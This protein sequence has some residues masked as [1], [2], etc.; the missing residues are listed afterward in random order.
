MNKKLFLLLLMA[1]CLT[2][3]SAQVWLGGEMSYQ[4]TDLHTNHSGTNTEHEFSIVPEIGF[5]LNEKWGVAT[6]LRFEHGYGGNHDMTNSFIIRPYV[7]YFWA[8]YDKWHI[9]TDG[10]LFFSSTHSCGTDENINSFG[11]F[12]SPGISYS[13]NDRFGLEAHLGDIT[14]RNKNVDDFKENN[15]SLMINTEFSIGFYVNL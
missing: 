11:V 3:A 10:G 9:L 4:M 6:Q 7:R 8:H 12:F 15:F 2:A 14:W 13:L 5:N 1:S